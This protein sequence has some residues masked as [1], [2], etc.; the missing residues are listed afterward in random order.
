ML[1]YLIQIFKQTFLIIKLIRCKPGYECTLV[2]DKCMI[3]KPC[4]PKGVCKRKFL[5]NIITYIKKFK[6]EFITKNL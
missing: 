3:G 4:K 2:Y 1:Q 5:L 6:L